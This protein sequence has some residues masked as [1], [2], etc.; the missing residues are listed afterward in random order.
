MELIWIRHLQT[1][2]NEKR[3][4]IG[5]TDEPLSEKTVEG[6]LKNPAEYSEVERVICSPMLRCIQTAELMFPGTERKTEPRLRECDFGQFE[7][8]TYEELKSVPKYIAWLKSNGTIPFPGGEEQSVFRRRSVEGAIEQI[9][10]LIEKKVQRAAFVV[11]G[12]TIMNI[13]EQYALPKK[14]FYEWHV[15]NGCG[16]LVELDPVLWKKDRRNLK[17]LEE[18]K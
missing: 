1:P 15:G 13:M 12:G 3:Q 11:H 8:K 2:G 4:Y 7:G 10:W 16:Y 5:S 9:E 18:R 14:E 17:L 6:F